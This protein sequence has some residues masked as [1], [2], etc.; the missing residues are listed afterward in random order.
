MLCSLHTDFNSG[1]SSKKGYMGI[2]EH[3][4]RL[5][6]NSLSDYK[7]PT[8]LD[9]LGLQLLLDGYFNRKKAEVKLVN[10]IMQ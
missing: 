10:A 2:I 5:T 3:A 6:Q 4:C 8:L 7:M 9:S 1:S